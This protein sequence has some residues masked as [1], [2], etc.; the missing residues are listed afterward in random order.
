M[1][2]LSAFERWWMGFNSRYFCS[3]APPPLGLSSSFDNYGGGKSSYNIKTSFLE[4]VFSKEPTYFIVASRMV[5][6]GLIY[7]VAVNVLHAAY[8]ITVHASISKDGVEI[9][10]DFQ[11]VK[12]GVPETLLMRIPPTSV[13]GKYKL[14]VEGLYNHV[15]GGI[16]F[17]NETD[18]VFSQRSMTIFIQTDKPLYK[19][20]EMVK[21]RAIPITTE[22]KGFDNAID[23][24][25]LD[26]TGHILRRWLSRQSNLG[27]RNVKWFLQHQS[28]DGAFYEVTWL[29]DRKMNKT[30]FTD[31]F[32]EV[33]QKTISLT[34]HVLITLAT[35]NDLSGNKSIFGSKTRFTIY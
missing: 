12:E 9:S 34:A 35:V 22:L 31:E 20:G 26:P 29:P 16:A 30:G 15:L 7:Q 23:V 4:T 13:Y 1:V 2:E 11:N 17:L 3:F 28:D 18:L 6:P 14:R 10:G 24:Y 32:G 27:S 19:Q 25:M 5:R 21:F 8:P 33:R